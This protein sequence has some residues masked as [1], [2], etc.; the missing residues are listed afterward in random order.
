[1]IVLNQLVGVE[2]SQALC[3]QKQYFFSIL[4]VDQE[5]EPERGLA[6]QRTFYF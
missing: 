2:R 1:M 3:V 4:L 6:L 5:P